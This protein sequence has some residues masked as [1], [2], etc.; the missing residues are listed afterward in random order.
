MIGKIFYQTKWCLCRYENSILDILHNTCSA[1]RCILQSNISYNISS[2][3]AAF[4][5]GSICF[6]DIRDATA[7]FNVDE[8]V[9]D[10]FY[11]PN[12]FK[13]NRI[14]SNG[15]KSIK[16]IKKVTFKNGVLK[17]MLELSHIPK[18]DVEIEGVVCKV[19][20]CIKKK[21]DDFLCKMK[22]GTMLSN[23]PNKITEYC[24]EMCFDKSVDID[25]LNLFIDRLYKLVQFINMDYMALIESV[26]VETNNGPL[27]YF[28]Q[29][30]NYGQQPIVRY[31]YIAN[32]KSIVQELSQKIL[33]DKYDM[34]FLSLIEKE[35]YTANDY[36]V[37]AQ[38]IE[39]NVNM[40]DIDLQSPELTVEI[41]FYINL[42]TVIKQTMK[43]FEDMN[44]KIDKDKKS[45]ILSLIEIPRFRQKIEFLYERFNEFAKQSSKY[46]E[47]E[48][49]DIKNLSQQVNNARNT[50]H[51]QSDLK[52]NKD[53]AKYGATLAVMSMYLYI[54]DE[55]GAENSTKFN[56]IQ[57]AF[58]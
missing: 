43:A 41:Q 32:C 5:D 35:N 22:Y 29:G 50:I 30:I 48:D 2:V 33:S 42:K 40:V 4:E 58:A 13:T 9:A 47:L 23:N 53:I 21:S 52:F 39:K 37:L 36:W 38:S 44:G 34:S 56:F 1:P 49:K 54:L 46:K 25:N 28:K 11:A 16:K 8:Y 20:F 45:F 18:F 57:C 10:R 24:I 14:K 7:L 27:L 19:C 55:C 15:I 17:P 12:Y 51:G 3:I 26:E 6:F 31:N